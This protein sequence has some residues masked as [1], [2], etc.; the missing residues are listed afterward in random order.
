MFTQCHHCGSRFEIDITQLKLA[1]GLVTCGKCKKEFNALETLHDERTDDARLDSGSKLVVPQ[2]NEKVPPSIDRDLNEELLVV[3]PSV[4]DELVDISL[5]ND[6][7]WQVGDGVDLADI[8]NIAEKKERPERK[9]SDDDTPPLVEGAFS[10]IK[11]PPPSS[12]STAAVDAEKIKNEEQKK[13][14]DDDPAKIPDQLLDKL[15]DNEDDFGKAAHSGLN[16]IKWSVAVMALLFLLALQYVYSAR[17][18]LAEH[19]G[20]RA[21]L[22]AMCS[23]LGCQ[24]PLKK[25]TDRIQLLHK[26]VQGHP[27][28]ENAL[29]VKATYSNKAPFTQPYPVVELVLS[30]IDQHVVVSRQFYPFEY[31]NDKSVIENGIA[32]D[33][34][35]QI[36]LE[37]VDPGENAVNFEFNFL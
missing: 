37:I 20:L 15:N 14:D 19:D 33:D 5:E 10:L 4:P 1:L 6:K 34:S 16:T 11:T 23:L 35:V 29:I 3:E 27:D 32:P 31:L 18:H 36:F 21:P 24:I 8:D 2:L 30:D 7:E 17:N 28:V 26:S 25:A 22:V 9:K 12:P 13:S